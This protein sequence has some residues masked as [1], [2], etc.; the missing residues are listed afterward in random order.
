LIFKPAG[1][2]ERFKL[3][4]LKAAQEH[5]PAQI[6]TAQTEAATLVVTFEGGSVVRMQ[7]LR[8]PYHQA[9]ATP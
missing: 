4:D 9:M 2:A 6:K 3:A 5:G 8:A 7:A 1:S